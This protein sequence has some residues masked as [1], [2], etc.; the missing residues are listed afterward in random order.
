MPYTIVRICS[1]DALAVPPSG[2][3]IC[4]VRE[5]SRYVCITQ[6]AK[7]ERVLVGLDPPVIIPCG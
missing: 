4:V 2:D 1:V 7:V 3:V 6:R 5:P